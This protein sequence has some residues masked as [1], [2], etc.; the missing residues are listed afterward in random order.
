MPADLL[1]ALLLIGGVIMIAAT[2]FVVGNRVVRRIEHLARRID[3]DIDGERVSM[4]VKVD[5]NE[6]QASL[7]EARVH[8]W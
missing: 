1:T 7:P 4:V 3:L 6:E 5:D 8:R 2:G